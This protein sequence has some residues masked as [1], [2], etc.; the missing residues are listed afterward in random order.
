MW[1]VKALKERLGPVVSD[2]ILVFHPMLDFDTTSR[3]YGIGKR[4]SMKKKIAVSQ[5]FRE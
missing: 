2:N 4:A 5:V 3:L 1:K